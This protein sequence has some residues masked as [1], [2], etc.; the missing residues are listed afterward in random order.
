M[1]A[2]IPAGL[3]MLEIVQEPGDTV[4]TPPGWLVA[5]EKQYNR[6]LTAGFP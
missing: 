3:G 6:T 5:G 1:A 2:K 4:Y